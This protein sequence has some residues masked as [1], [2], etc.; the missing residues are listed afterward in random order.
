MSKFVLSAF[1]DEIAAGLKTQLDVLEEHDIRYIELRGVDGRNLVDYSLEEAAGIK[2]ILDKRRIGVSSIGSPVGKIGIQ[3]D[4]DAHLQLFRHTLDLAR[5]FGTE[6]IRMF[7][8]YIPEGN[9]PL[10]YRDEVLRR[11]REFIRAAAGTGIT[12]LHENEKHIYGDTAE[13]CL[14]LLESLD[15]PM[16][17]AVFDPAN[18]VQ[19]GVET[20][21]HAYSLLKN[22]IGYMHIKDALFRDSS[23]VPAG[24]GD[25]H[26]EEILRELH[27]SGFEGFL[28]IEPHLGSFAGFAA[29]E[30]HAKVNRLPEGGPKQFSIAVYALKKVLNKIYG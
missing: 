14:D 10:L 26:V 23:V 21:P 1:G 22:H 6:Y 13:R 18:F 17:R 12:L 2:E 9:D 7:S 30:P 20:Y 3:D 24:Y 15:C 27:Q 25:G 16:V 19:C 5:L 29:L 8:F 28:S 4:F 11:W